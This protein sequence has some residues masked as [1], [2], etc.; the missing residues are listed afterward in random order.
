M[1]RICVFAGSSQG[2]DPAYLE[3]T[4]MLGKL[5]AEKGIELVYGGAKSGLMGVLADEVLKGGGNVTGIMPTRLFE[6]EIVHP[7]ITTMVEVETLHE[8]KSK[9]SELADG[10]IALPGGFGT[11]EELFETISWA[12]IGIHTKPVALYNIKGYYTPL[13][14]LI[15]HAIQAGFVP[16][17]NR[18]LIINSDH[19][20]KLLELMHH[21]G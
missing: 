13:V 18:D 2:N 7:D 10:Y 5:F 14:N 15:D 16:E 11:F 1:K 21:K 9:M 12:Q 19:P 20:E 17:D 3:K 8:R 4:Q 6:K